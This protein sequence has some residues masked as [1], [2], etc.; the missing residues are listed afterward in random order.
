MPQAVEFFNDQIPVRVAITSVPNEPK[1]GAPAP[2][3]NK[4]RQ[5]AK[6][7]ERAAEGVT[8]AVQFVC[9]KHVAA[10]NG[11][12]AG[13][14]TCGCAFCHMQLGF[15]VMDRAEGPSTAGRVII[16]RLWPTT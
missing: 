15:A 6:Q 12:T 8:E 3:G 2:K 7:A 10:G 11:L 1:A 4:A 14:F 9:H 5:Q 13:L 16:T